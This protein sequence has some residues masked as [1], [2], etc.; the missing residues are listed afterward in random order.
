MGKGGWQP[1]HKVT[2]TTK[3]PCRRT[4]TKRCAHAHSWAALLQ[5]HPCQ[6]ISQ[7]ATGADHQDPGSTLF[8]VG[9][10]AMSTSP[11]STSQN[12]RQHESGH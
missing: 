5:P 6:P 9:V 11:L 4:S 2:C 12:C 8:E 10:T 7:Q 1:Q 3:A